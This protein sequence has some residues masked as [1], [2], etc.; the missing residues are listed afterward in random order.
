MLSL[1]SS[2]SKYYQDS[3]MLDYFAYLNKY[4]EV[5]VPTYFITTKGFNFTSEEGMNAVCSSVGC[6]QF[7]FMQK[8]RYA[9]EYPER[10]ALYI[11]SRHVLL[12]KLKMSF[13][14]LVALLY[15]LPRFASHQTLNF[16]ICVIDLESSQWHGPVKIPAL[17]FE[18]YTMKW[19]WQNSFYYFCL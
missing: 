12:N 16:Q 18:N 15:T 9:T 5:G 7:S 10:W 2:V 4:F 6:D 14:A 11:S 3:Y 8:I 13:G 17:M 19:Q 1:T